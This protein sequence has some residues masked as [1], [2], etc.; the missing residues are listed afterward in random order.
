MNQYNRPKPLIVVFFSLIIFIIILIGL[1]AYMSSNSTIQERI[2]YG[3][4]TLFPDLDIKNKEY[5]QNK[6]EAIDS[7]KDKNWKKAIN[8]LKLSLGTNNK[9]P[10]ELSNNTKPLINDPEALIY[11]NNAKIEYEKE[12]S[13]TIAVSIPISKNPNSSLEILRGVA[14]AQNEI[15]CLPKK[16][17]GLPLKVAIASDDD[18]EKV[19]QEV[20]KALVGNQGGDGIVGMVVAIPWHIDSNPKSEFATKSKNL[21]GAKVSWR[22]ALAYDAT[23]ALI[24]G[25]ER[26]PTRSGV[27]KALS[28]KDFLI[29][30]ASGTVQFLPSGDRKNAPVQ[31]VKIIPS[32][33]TQSKYEFQ[34]MPDE[35]D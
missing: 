12:K 8:D 20:A 4:K 21:W 11:L 15:N 9:C 29:N 19:A 13:Y 5:T 25:I 35:P 18:D 2:S 16:I 23:L 34:P 7:I 24:T 3:E 27:Q 31:L 6:Q 14:Q 32:N 26:N 22:T 1:N 10:E 17:K 33:G 30:G 28:S